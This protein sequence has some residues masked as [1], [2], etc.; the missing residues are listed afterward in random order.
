LE[1]SEWKKVF[2]VYRGGEASTGY[3]GDRSGRM[4]LEGIEG[5]VEYRGI[6][7]IGV[8]EVVWIGERVRGE[9]WG[10]EES[11]VEEGIW[12]VQR[13]RGEYRGIGET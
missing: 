5:R 7:E 3:W 9:Y 1:R 11:G 12:R 2:G 13:G 4:Y 6:R 8:E 10:I